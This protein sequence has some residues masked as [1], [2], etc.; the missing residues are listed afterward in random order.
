MNIFILDLDHKKNA[1][2][3]SNTHCIKLILEA[4]QCLC[5]AHWETGSEAPYR[6]TH[7][8]HPI[9]KWIRKSLANYRWVCDYGMA[10]CDEYTYRY[11]KVHATQKVLEWCIKNQPNIQDSTLTEFALAMPDEYKSVDPVESYRR[12]V[13]AEKQTNK[14]GKFMLNY[15]VR[16]APGWLKVNNEL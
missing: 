4:A 3:H 10:L 1:E 16:Q 11:G 6:A 8:N 5:T 15:S 14:S 9:N 7:K 2:Y 12:Y 13:I